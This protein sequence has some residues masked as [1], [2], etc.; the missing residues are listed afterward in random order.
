VIRLAFG[1]V[2]G[3]LLTAS[4][5]AA[6][7]ARV[8]NAPRWAVDPMAAEPNLPPVGRSLFDYL[9]TIEHN[10]QRFYNVPFPY[11]EFIRSIDQRLQGAG[12]VTSQVKQVLMPLGRSLQRNAATPDYFRFPRVVASVDSEPGP[13]GDTRLLLKDRLYIGF[14][15][16]SA[17]LEVISYNEAAG[18]FEFQ[19]VNDYRPGGTPQVAYADRAVC[20]SCHQNAAPIFS[21]QTWD[22]TNANPQ[23]AALLSKHGKDFHGVTIERGVDIPFAIDQATQRANE[24]ALT[25]LLWREGCGGGSEGARCRGYALALALQYRLSGE[26]GFDS[27]ASGSGEALNVVLQTQWRERWPGGLYLPDATLPNR[28][29]LQATN[30]AAAR[31]E[32]NPQL[33]AQ[34]K[35][36][37][38]NLLDNTDIRAPFEPLDPRAPRTTWHSTEPG[39]AERLVHGVAEFIAMSDARRL[40]EELFKRPLQTT[41]AVQK[42]TTRCEFTTKNVNGSEARVG[43]LCRTPERNTDTTFLAEGRAY[44]SAGKITRAEVDSLTFNGIELRALDVAISASVERRNDSWTLTLPL[45]QNGMHVRAFDGTA[46]DTLTLRGRNAYDGRASTAGEAVLAV[47]DDFA[48]VWGAV[49]VL[50]SKASADALSDRPLRRAA[51]LPALFAQLGV[52]PGAW[53]CVDDRG[54][55]PLLDDRT[56]KTSAQR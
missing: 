43:F 19:V 53:C 20:V 1:L 6:D 48:P 8:S 14:G 23:I 40:D 5:V 29:P 17:I 13:H 25:Q 27:H 32:F 54:M 33:G 21:R 47:R 46:L 7:K 49:N 3:C 35:K 4:V 39:I 56:V 38:Q 41:S 31:F 42:L 9:V 55:P 10:G 22:E 37:L 36:T 34:G 26:R 2:C 18:R 11:T 28:N 45:A 44:L 15:E 12:F 52:A 16:K 51:L 30:G 50:M 24:F